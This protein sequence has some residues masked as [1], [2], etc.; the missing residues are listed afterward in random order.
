MP[1]NKQVIQYGDLPNHLHILKGA[2]DTLQYHIV[3]L[4]LRQGDDLACLVFK[5]QCAGGRLIKL[6]DTVEH[7][8]FTCTV[9]TDEAEN[10]TLFHIKGKAVYSVDTTEIHTQ[11]LHSQHH[12]LRQPRS[13]SRSELQFSQGV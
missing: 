12:A 8:G 5:Q 10:F 2:D 4:F 1:R 9:G 6:G 7:S 3:Y 13:V 11:I